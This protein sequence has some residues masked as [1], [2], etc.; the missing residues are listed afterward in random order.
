MIG[1]I[2][3]YYTSAVSEI[4]T[5]LCLA[6]ASGGM[7][8]VVFNELLPISYN[9]KSAFSIISGVMLGLIVIFSL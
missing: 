7:S 2:I 4:F 3:S 9:K 5:S 6:I 8:Y 1:G